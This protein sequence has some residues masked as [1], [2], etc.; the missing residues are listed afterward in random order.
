MLLNCPL[1]KA[2]YLVNSADLLSEGRE[3]KCI[4]CNF[5]WFQNSK[6]TTSE[7]HIDKNTNK[8]KENKKIDYSK[9]LPSTYVEAKKS[10]LTNSILMV[11]FI[12]IIVCLY[13]VFIN[14]DNGIMN[15]I[16]YYFEEFISISELLIN[17]FLKVIKNFSK[18][19]YDILK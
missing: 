2:Q 3:V 4:K 19:L 13:F 16:M 10:S 7:K 18:I 14:L 15:L 5:Q 17:D 6:L 11:L 8:A 1:C 12:T 9:T